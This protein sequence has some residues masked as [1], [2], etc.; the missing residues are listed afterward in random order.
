M[1]KK[2]KEKLNKRNE[3]FIL[4][5]IILVVAL[6]G[7]L[8]LTYPPMKDNSMFLYMGEG[9]INGD[10]PYLDNFD[11]KP[12]GI[13]FIYAFIA[14]V[15]GYTIKGVYFFDLLWALITSLAIWKLTKYFFGSKEGL[16]A[17]FLYGFLY[18]TYGNVWYY[19]QAEA[20]SNLPI[21]LGIY[22]F[23]LAQDQGKKAFFFFS[24]LF[25]GIAFLIKFPLI[26]GIIFLLLFVFFKGNEKKEKTICFFMFLFGFFILFFPVVFYFIFHNVLSKMLYTLLV[27]TPQYAR[28]INIAYTGILQKIIFSL[29]K[30]FDFFSLYT[31]PLA[32]FSLF[33][34]FGIFN[35][36]FTKK[37]TR[38]GFHIKQ[39]KKLFLC[40]W[41]VL[42][43]LN[44]AI[45]GKFFEHH[46]IPVYVPLSIISALGIIYFLKNYK[47]HK[48]LFTIIF[49]FTMIFSTIFFSRLNCFYRDSAKYLLGK[50]PRRFYF[51]RFGRFPSKYDFSPNTNEFLASYIKQNTQA[52]DFIYIWGAHPEIYVLSNRR[53][54]SKFLMTHQL[55][56]SWAPSQWREDFLRELNEKFP[57]L[58]IVTKGDF[59][60]EVSGVMKDSWQQLKEFRR[61]DSFLEEN[62]FLAKEID[63][64]SVYKR[65]GGEN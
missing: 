62:Y 9:I 47:K 27:Y 11:M 42:C 18:F 64:F 13:F 12:P 14:K 26:M 60:P 56:C 28:T 19:G 43:F 61:L 4:G 1:D 57:R 54:A 7:L 53:S 15:F 65:K 20:F 38:D 39:N 36:N 33:G 8:I 3:K 22:F 58:F 63:M 21:I 30:I 24:G 46:W 52:E 25:L 48:K 45:Q 51:S 6:H 41:Y 40:G 16:I 17:G 59:F 29:A 10:V 23:F 37:E 5:V 50:M 49:C 31:G 32:V 2:V 35:N 44:V 34:I 55:Y